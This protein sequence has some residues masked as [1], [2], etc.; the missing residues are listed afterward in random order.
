MSKILRFQPKAKGARAMGTDNIRAGNLDATSACLLSNGEFKIPFDCENGL[1][2]VNEENVRRP[3]N[4]VPFQKFKRKC[5]R[6]KRGNR[7]KSCSKVG[8][9]L[10]RLQ[11]K[12]IAVPRK[13]IANCFVNS[14]LSCSTPF[15]ETTRSHQLHLIPSFFINC[16]PEADILHSQLLPGPEI[17]RLSSFHCRRSPC[18]T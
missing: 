9:L 3:M 10:F 6:R 7:T 8:M 18:C 14:R 13:N 15:I 17:I 5:K 12:S 11:K 16:H 2:C 1:S 4:P